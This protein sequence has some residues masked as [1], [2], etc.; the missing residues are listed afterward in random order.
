MRAGV[1]QGALDDCYFLNAL[2]AATEECLK[3]KIVSDEYRG[4]GI[5]TVKFF[6]GGKVSEAWPTNRAL[7]CDCPCTLL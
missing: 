1:V 5:Y 2:E 4:R 6:K 7:C 3:D